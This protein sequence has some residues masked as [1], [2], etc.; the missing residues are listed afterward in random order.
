MRAAVLHE[1]GAPIAGD[2]QEPSAGPGQAVVEV[3]AAGLNPVG[4]AGPT[5]WVS[6]LTAIRRP[7]PVGL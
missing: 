2:F 4:A 6:N 3:L 5:N 7:C 1:Y